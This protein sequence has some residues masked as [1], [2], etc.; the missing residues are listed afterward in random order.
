M[1]IVEMIR[2]I[3]ENEVRKIHTVELG[4]VTSVF[5][6]STPS[7]KDNYECNVR[8]KNMNI[9]LQRVQIATQVIGLA[10]PPRVGD[11]V[12]VAFVNGDVNMPVVIGRL[13]NDEDRPPVSNLEEIVYIPPYTKK[14]D[15]RRIYIEFPEG[16]ILRI[17]DDEVMVKAGETRVIIQHNGDVVIES[18]ANI[19]VKAEGDTS[20]R[21]KGN[22]SISASNI[23]INSEKNLSIKSGSDMKL[24]S[25]ANAE[26]TSRSQ[27]KVEASA[28]MRIRGATVHIN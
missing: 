18:K 9:E 26:F 24:T 3:A 7:D 1:S 20:I 5:P 16:M 8:L 19:T 2:R 15:R 27:M 6:H 22:L 25:D 4:I 11:L 10:E 14:T 23:E 28:Q 12:L 13:Y 21:S 17:K